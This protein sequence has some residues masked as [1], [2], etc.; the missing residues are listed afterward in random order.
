VSFAGPV[1]NGTLSFSQAWR[2]EV[3][4]YF[5]LSRIK[6][7]TLTAGVAFS[8]WHDDE[9]T[10]TDISVFLTAGFSL[11]DSVKR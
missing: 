5:T 3:P 7:K 8:H 9:G 6:D 1:S 11:L 2:V 4:L 10:Y